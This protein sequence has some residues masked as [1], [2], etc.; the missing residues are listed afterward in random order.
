M[1][2]GKTLAVHPDATYTSKG[3]PAEPILANRLRLG[4]NGDQWQLLYDTVANNELHLEAE[5][6]P[7][8]VDTDQLVEARP[9]PVHRFLGNL[10]A[11]AVA[12]AAAPSA[13]SGRRI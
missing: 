2:W 9:I 6:T 1:P 10:M 8:H 11:D 5:R 3:I 12:G 7:A 4:T 13:Q